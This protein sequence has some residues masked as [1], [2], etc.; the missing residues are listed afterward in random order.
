MSKLFYTLLILCVLPGALLAQIKISG[1]VTSPKKQPLVGV[2]VYIKGSYDGATTAKDG[3]YS[4]TTDVTGEAILVASLATMGSIEV[5]VELNAPSLEQN[6]VLKET[7][8]ELK[9]VTISSGAFEASDTKKNTVLKP[10]DIVTTGGANADIVAALKTLPGAQQVG[11]KEGLFVRGGTGYETQT[12]IDG[13]LVRNPFYSGMP[14]FATR[15][16]FSP[17]L[18]KG[19]TFSSGGYSALY[20][21]GLSSALILETIDLPD[22]S[23]SSVNLSSIGFGGAYS[24][25]AKDKKSSYG[26]EANYMNLT[27]YFKLV[28]QVNEPSTYPSGLNT[29]ANFRVKTSK[30][31]M[32]KF[33]GAYSRNAFG[34]KINSLQYP[35]ALEAFDLNNNNAYGN[36]TYRERINENWK[37]DMGLSYS[38]NIDKI[39]MD[40]LTKDIPTVNIRSTQ[41]LTQYRTVITRNFGHSALRF[42]AEYQFDQEKMRYNVYDLNYNDHYGAGF[43]E[44]DIYFTPRLVARLG[45][46]YEYS[47]IIKAANIAPRAYLAYRTGVKGQVSVSYGTF[48]QKPEQQYIRLNHDLGYMRAT[49]YIAA[50]QYI[51]TQHVFRTELFYKKYNDLLKTTPTLNTSGTGYAKGVEFYWRDK[52]TIK[53]GDYWISYSY[54][55]TKRDYLNYPFQVQPDFA[56]N[57]TASF[58]YKQ[59]F[60]KM[61]TYLGATYT[62]ATGRPYYNPTRPESEFMKDRTKSY[63]TVGFNANYITNIRKAF[64]VFVF[65]VTNALGTDQVYGYRYSNDALRRAAVGPMAPRFFFV[66]MFMSFGIDRSKEV[67]EN[68]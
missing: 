56:A 53:N 6:I 27:P 41:A 22:Q 58:V 59:Y 7:M 40:T 14:D 18:F 62:F 26:V 47:S 23:S 61:K 13:M 48:Y 63:N 17:F 35:G 8:N 45:A 3:S 1:R 20:G 10:L 12:F 25:L 36:L 30:S 28:P 42:G 50:Y 2:N 44:G 57:H 39:K 16:R 15:G 21:Q 46:R 31:G 64:T 24:H 60:P 66:G 29:T 4:F 67:I 37:L 68:N 49:H 52:K 65:T 43:A 9:M 19:T 51:S 33:Y 32:L 55:D 5:K 38:Y 34:F 11:E 54:L